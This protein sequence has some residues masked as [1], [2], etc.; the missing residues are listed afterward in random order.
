MPTHSLPALVAGR[1][2]A[3]QGPDAFLAYHEALLRAFFEENRDIARRRVLIAVARETGLDVARFAQDMVDRG[4]RAA[5]MSELHE[6]QQKGIDGIP[7]AIFADAQGVI[8]VVG[9][10][11]LDQYR[12]LVNW[13]LA[14]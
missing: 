7:T 9:E 12:R 8:R 4:H 11:P 10:V 2:A 6:A 3:L 5:V 14:T 1:A 13:L